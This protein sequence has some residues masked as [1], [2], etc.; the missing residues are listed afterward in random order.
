MLAENFHARNLLN[1]EGAT[2]LTLSHPITHSI[3]YT[4]GEIFPQ[5][6]SINQRNQRVL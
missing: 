3:R 5:T 6:D 1:L 2:H 4:L